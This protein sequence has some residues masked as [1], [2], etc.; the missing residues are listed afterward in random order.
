MK[1]YY[2][3]VSEA[4]PLRGKSDCNDGYDEWTSRVVFNWSAARVSNA[5]SSHEGIW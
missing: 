4:C 3:Y 5:R 2:G 1:L